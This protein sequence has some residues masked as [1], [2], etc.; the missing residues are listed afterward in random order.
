MGVEVEGQDSAYQNIITKI[1]RS[2]LKERGITRG[3]KGISV[4]FNVFVRHLLKRLEIYVIG[5]NFIVMIIT[6]VSMST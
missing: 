1:K 3:K 4:N 5:D 6:L 2:L